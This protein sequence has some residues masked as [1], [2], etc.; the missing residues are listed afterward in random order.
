[1]ASS[2]EGEASEVRLQTAPHGKGICEVLYSGEGR[3]LTT[4]AD[5]RLACS[6][7]ETGL[8]LWAQKISKGLGSP[9]TAAISSDARLLAVAEE[10]DSGFQVWVHLLDAKGRVAQGQ[11]PR[12]AGRFTLD[13]R[14]LSWHSTLPYLCMGTDDGKVDLWCEASKDSKTPSR[15]QLCSL[16]GTLGGV[17]GACMDSTAELVSVV[18]SSG[19]VAVF[20]VWSTERYRQRLL[21]RG[22][23][24][25]L[26]AW[27]PTGQQLALPG[28][29]CVRLLPRT[30]D[31][32]PVQLEG[33]HRFSTNMA[34]WS[35]SGHILVTA[36]FEALAIWVSG[37]LGRI[38]EVTVEPSSMVWDGELLAF[39]TQAGHFAYLQAESVDKAE[40]T[41]VPEATPNEKE[42]QDE[43]AEPQID[44]QDQAD[45]AT[46][47]AVTTLRLGTKAI[48]QSRFQPGATYK[49]RRRFLAWNE[50][51]SL[52]LTLRSQEGP[53]KKKLALVAQVEVEYYRRRDPS[54]VRNIKTGAC[55]LG[56]VGAIGPGLCAVAGNSRSGAKIAV[57]FATP[58]KHASFEHALYGERVES[59][60]ITPVFLAVFVS[61]HRFLR[62]FT[63]SFVPVSVLSVGSIVSMVGRDHLLFC[64][65]Q[66]KRREPA[67]EFAIWHAERGERLAS[68]PLPLSAQATL[69]WIGFSAEAQPLAL[70]SVGALRMLALGDAFVPA[71][72]W[73]PVADIQPTLWPVEARDAALSC[74]KGEPRVGAV[75]RFTSVAYKVPM[76]EAG[77]MEPFLRQ[78]L[79][80]S[81]QTF[82]RAWDLSGSGK[83]A[84]GTKRSQAAQTS[85]KLFEALLQSK[86]QEL[87]RDLVGLARRLGHP[88][89]KAAEAATA[90]G[91]PELATLLS[92]TSEPEAAQA[93]MRRVE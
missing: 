26:M 92:Q 19:D 27:D 12:N 44:S 3:L 7:T 2:G 51:G 29:P 28:D 68:G 50:H 5:G 35:P 43:P 15:K 49:G 38:V 20:D 54:C 33:G 63:P 85:Q 45:E 62:I 88:V 21:P 87:A 9:T 34:S 11:K 83:K 67:L 89:E 6:E 31:K 4:G 71:G 13:I 40:S 23:D 82:A 86:D 66:K 55:D 37:R 24:R 47:D 73:I 79:L 70:D 75:Y 80:S 91:L 14:H 10:T 52:Q 16:G 58:W 60:T 36:S 76:P 74:V 30:F 57:H 39:G 41:E 48:C 32:D 72:S 46:E 56:A 1:M 77:G 22:T 18:F 93:K 53:K 81:H 25:L 8:R 65:F 78:S 59:L 42:T 90:A 61:P 69:K 64:V 84:K 17:R